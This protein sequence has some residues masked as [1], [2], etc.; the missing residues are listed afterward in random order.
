MEQ[1]RT[2]HGCVDWNIAETYVPTYYLVPQHECVDWNKEVYSNLTIPQVVPLMGRGG[3]NFMILAIGAGLHRRTFRR[4]VD[5][6][7]LIGGVGCEKIVAPFWVRGLK[8][9]SRFCLCIV[10]SRTLLGAWIETSAWCWRRNPSG[11]APFGLGVRGLKLC[12]Y[13]RLET[14][15]MS[16]PLGGRGLKLGPQGS[17]LRLVLSH[18]WGCVDWNT[19]MSPTFAQRFCRTF[20]RMEWKTPDLGSGVFGIVIGACIKSYLITS[21]FASFSTFYL[22]PPFVDMLL[23]VM[24]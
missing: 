2:L 11:V 4:C 15:G 16:H 3:W 8:L 1:C 9:F 5:W 23:F 21:F 22:A 12:M 14:D 10:H 7:D 17:Y 19:Q 20:M 18:P 6:N 13:V 24:L